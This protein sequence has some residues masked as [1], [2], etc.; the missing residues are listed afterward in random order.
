MPQFAPRYPDRIFE[1]IARLDDER[2]PLAEVARSVGDAAQ[3][4]GLTR[5]SPVHL[6]RLLADLRA[7][8][9]DDGEIRD[10]ALETVI[11]IATGRIPDPLTVHRPVE[12]AIERAE[13]RAR[14]RAG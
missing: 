4:E 5:P 10:A 14:R 2:R 3:A 13:L 11:R 6:R 12:R 8:R 9:R 7:Q 1:L